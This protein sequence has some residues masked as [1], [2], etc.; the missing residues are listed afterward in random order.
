MSSPLKS[1]L[2][3]RILILSLSSIPLWGIKSNFLLSFSLFPLSSL[4]LRFSFNLSEN[5]LLITVILISLHAGIFAKLYIRKE[6]NL[7][8][9]IFTIISFITSI[10]LFI[11]RDSLFSLL[12]GWDGLGTSSFFL[13]IWYQRWNRFDSGIVT[14]L[15]NRLGD[16]FLIFRL[17]RYLNFGWIHRRIA[18][19]SILSSLITI[20]CLTKRAQLPFR[21]WLP[22]AIRAPTPIRALVHSRT[23]VTSGLFISI[24]LQRI[25]TRE[26]LFILGCCTIFIAGIIRLFEIDL[27]KIVALS[28]LRQLG[29]I[30]TII[31]LGLFRL[32]FFHIIRHAFIKRALFILV[33]I[34]LH[35]NLSTQDKRLLFISRNWNSYCITSI[36]LCVIALIGITF[37]RGLITKETLLLS[38]LHPKFS[39]LRRV[40]I[41]ISIRFTFMYSLRI[42]KTCNQGGVSCLLFKTSIKEY[43]RRRILVILRVRRTWFISDNFFY[44]RTPIRSHE[45]RGIL[46]LLIFAILL[47]F[48]SH[49]FHP[50]SINLMGISLFLKQISKWHLNLSKRDRKH[51]DFLNWTLL[52]WSSFFSLLFKTNK[53]KCINLILLFI[54]LSFL[55]L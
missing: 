15:T 8:G 18:F 17:I 27:K 37:T 20:A 2:S 33:G 50:F 12:L 21:V 19:N 7:S 29:F 41:M 40:F 48:T 10:L 44:V 23:L 13:I 22:F 53:S 26:I 6:T 30:A 49:L 55:F 35:Y 28:T 52:W 36:T 5:L 4:N 43:T 42:I 54:L 25:L 46:L 51:L 9:F 47:S 38:S 31:G 32:T 39:R 3:K 45:R 34:H 14:L 11:R 24:K 16:F 1:I